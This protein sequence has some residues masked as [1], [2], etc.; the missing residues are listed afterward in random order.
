MHTEKNRMKREIKLAIIDNSIDPSI[1]NPLAHWGAS[2]DVEWE[3]F[4]ASESQFPSLSKEYTHLILTGSEASIVER[5]KWVYEEVE[6]VREAVDKGISVL[7][8]CYGHQ[9][10]ALALAGFDHVRRSP[11]PEVGWIS[12]Q[13]KEDDELLGRK[14]EAFSFTSHFDEVIHLGSDFHVLASSTYCPIQAF[15]FKSRPVWGIQIHPEINIEEGR[16][17]LKKLVSLG[18]KTNPFFERALNTAS[19]DSCL[20]KTIVKTFLR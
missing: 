17:F 16:K 18:L 14:G 8:S 20:I 19:R 2:I 7:G 12:I 6:F 13:I 1:Y 5:E 15:Q 11:S 3:G 9:L 10:L 4:R